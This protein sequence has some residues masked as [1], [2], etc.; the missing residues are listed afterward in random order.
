MNNIS[1]KYYID[2]VKEYLKNFINDVSSLNNEEIIEK[3]ILHEIDIHMFKK[4]PRSIP[5]IIKTIGIIKQIHPLSLL[6]IGCGKGVFLWTLLKEFPNMEVTAIDKNKNNID[7]LKKVNHNNKFNLKI[8]EEDISLKKSY[9]KLGLYDMVTM[10]EVLE[11]IPDWNAAIYNAVNLTR[12]WVIISF[13]SKPDNNEDHINLLFNEN[14]CKILK[15]YGM[16]SVK[17]DYVNGHKFIIGK[18]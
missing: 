3:S 14:I 10:L 6:E 11:H 5:R 7:R 9:D 8:F 16:N 2:F 13:P 18:K 12:K 15:K 4:S 1:E 17:E